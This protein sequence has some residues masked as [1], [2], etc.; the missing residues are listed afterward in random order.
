MKR[1]KIIWC[2]EWDSDNPN[3]PIFIYLVDGMCY[4]INEP[5]DATFSKNSKYYLQK[6]SNFA[7]DYEFAHSVYTN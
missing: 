2:E 3:S 5:S 4:E 6:F 7:L 1:D